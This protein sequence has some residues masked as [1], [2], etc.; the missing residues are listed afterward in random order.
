MELLDR[1][2]EA[3]KKYLP[4]E[5]QDD[6][7]AELKANLE[8]Q[9]ED[10]EAELGRP[11]TKDEAGEWV[12]QLGPPIHMAA[13]YQPQR[14]LI[15]PALFP[16]Y[17]YVLQLACTWALVIW[18]IVT[19]V[20]V[21]V[22]PNPVALEPLTAVLQAPGVLFT[23]AAWV[24]LI[25]AIIEFASG[26]YPECFKNTP[27]ASNDWSPESL[28]TAES[29]GKKRGSFANLV[30]E[31]IFGFI[32]LLWL[33]LVPAH[34]YLLLGPGAAYLKASPFEP[35]PGLVQFYW[36]AVAFNVI[37]LGWRAES[38]LRGRWRAEQPIQQVALKVLGLIPSL[39][40]VAA[41]DH[42]YIALK[43]PELDTVRYGGTLNSINQSLYK[44]VLLVCAFVVLQLAW[45]IGKRVLNAY[46]KRQAAR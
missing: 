37:Q 4:W 7:V 30:A 20:L 43:H 33:L 2:V 40:L 28:P 17:R 35:A 25:F 16:F 42:V 32:F 15:G 45:E 24:T 46:R 23:T 10:K 11:L 27:L 3:I 26:R 41:R 1:Y 22:R 13:R 19:V 34:P 29:S 44:G 21:F 36:A 14:S 38:L 12:K 9:L 6:I 18:S 5:R 31:V 8:S 39:V